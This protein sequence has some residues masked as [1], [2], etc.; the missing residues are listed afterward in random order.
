[1]YMIGASFE[2]VW[3]TSGAALCRED[4]GPI[5]LWNLQP[6]IQ[7]YGLGRERWQLQVYTCNQ[8][9]KQKIVI[10]RLSRRRETRI[11]GNGFFCY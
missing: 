9:F 2:A 8:R 7:P 11:P 5:H 3:C 4:I 10:K 6:S 1:M